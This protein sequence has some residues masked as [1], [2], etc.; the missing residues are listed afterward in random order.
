MK[1]TILAYNR[2]TPEMIQPYADE[3]DIVLT[4]P[5]EPDF[6]RVFQQALPR[7]HG[8]IGSNLKLGRETLGNAPLLEVVSTISVGY[9]NC[10]VQYLR[11]KGIQ[12]TNT[13]NVLNASTADLA[14][15]LILATAR[16]IPELDAWTKSGQWDRTIADAE[17]GCDVHGKTLG[18]IGM[19]NIGSA[20]AQRGRWGFDMRIL[21]S[22]KSRKPEL[23]RA[24]DAHFVEMD[25]LLAEA[26]FICPVVPLNEQTRHLLSHRE[27]ALMK[28]GAIVVNVSRGPV[29]DEQALVEALQNNTIRGAG[30]DV[31][32]QEP[33]RSS[34]LFDMKQV[35]TVPHIGS[36][37]AETRLAMARLALQN[38]ICALRGERP[39]N[40]VKFA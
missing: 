34:P 36:A 6:D 24:L 31:F 20:I 13:P 23:E 10:D 16:R 4:H 17:F 26:D 37:T 25:Q 32:E 40:L 18:I 12:L 33:L 3:F 11:E 2:V 35:V 1:K 27:F 9:D 39:K 38:L 19:G 8:L 30:L 21:Y 22:G 14:F 5:G 29:V 28:P 7:V 15:A